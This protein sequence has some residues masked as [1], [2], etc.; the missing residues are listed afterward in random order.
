MTKCHYISKQK[1]KLLIKNL[2][3]K[4]KNKQVIIKNTILSE[5][6]TI[7]IIFIPD[8]SRALGRYLGW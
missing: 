4:M 2:H 3:S 5:N 7:E 1:V 8:T 6:T